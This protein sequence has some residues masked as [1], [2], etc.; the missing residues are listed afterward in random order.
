MAK[1]S[2]C[3][4]VTFRSRWQGT[5]ALRLSKQSL[6]WA[7]LEESGVVL[8]MIQSKSNYLRASF[9]ETIREK[10]RLSMISGFPHSSSEDEEEEE[11]EEPIQFSRNVFSE[12]HC[13]PSSQV[14]FRFHE[15]FERVVG[16]LANRWR[17]LPMFFQSIVDFSIAKTR[18]LSARRETKN[19]ITVSNDAN[20][21]DWMFHCS[22]HYLGYW[23]LDH[24]RHRHHRFDP[25]RNVAVSV[26]DDW[27][28]AHLDWDPTTNIQRGLRLQI[29]WPH[30]SWLWCSTEN[31]QWEV[32]VEELVGH[33]DEER[34]DWSLTIHISV[35]AADRQTSAHAYTHTHMCLVVP[36][37]GK[38]F[39]ESIRRYS[40]IKAMYPAWISAIWM[41]VRRERAK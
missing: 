41:L 6:R 15:I 21:T 26:L 7:R 32:A 27:S 11:I 9:A 23:C 30:W 28:D 29:D 12:I 31:W 40:R 39:F 36:R 13:S 34:F 33:L 1:F 16:D 10:I 5:S 8:H 17:Y 24:R 25:R 38:R 2:T 37:I 19:R 18:G 3:R 20:P 35:F 4:L 14:G 22:R